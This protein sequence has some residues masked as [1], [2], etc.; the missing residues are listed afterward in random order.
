M[1]NVEKTT[2][3]LRISFS[4]I[5]KL[6]EMNIWLEDSMRILPVDPK[7]FYVFVD[8][9]DLK[10]ISLFVQRVMDKGQQLYKRKGMIRSVVIVNNPIVKR[11]FEKIAIESG[12][13]D[14]ER[15]IDAMNNPDWEVKGM[16]WLLNAI[17]PDTGNKLEETAKIQSVN[18]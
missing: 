18:Q 8:M 13:Y 6:E 1:F 7:D 16:E 10:P 2:Y 12:I 9:R 5:I 15:Y 14:W 17:D 3:G 11:Q 4:D